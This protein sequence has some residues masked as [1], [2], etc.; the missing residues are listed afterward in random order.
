MAPQRSA[1]VMHRGFGTLLMVIV[2]GSLTLGLALWVSTSSLW[3]IRSSIDNQSAAQA[4]ALVNACAEVALELV[5]EDQT[6]TGTRS[7]TLG[8]DTCTA[9]IT[10]TGGSTRRITVSG[11]VDSVSRKI[12]ITTSSFNPLTVSSWGEV[13]DF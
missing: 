3:S 2:L 7:V 4:K 6:Y 8:N 5:R 11:T 9:T 10:D 12:D 1:N 13:A